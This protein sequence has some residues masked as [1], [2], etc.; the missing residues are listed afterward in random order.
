[1]SLHQLVDQLEAMIRDAKETPILGGA[2]ID[3]ESVYDLVDQ[4]RASIE[5][6][7]LDEDHGT[8]RGAGALVP[9]DELDTFMYDAKS[10][11][12]TGS[13]R[14]D[15][16]RLLAIVGRVR[17]GAAQDRYVT[18]EE[19]ERTAVDPRRART[20]FDRLDTL[21]RKARPVPLTTQVRLDKGAVAKV[22]EEL[23]G[24]GPVALLPA[25]DA[26]DD[27]LHNAHPVPLT[28]EV[29]V[30]RATLSEIYQQMRAGFSQGTP[31]ALT[32]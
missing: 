4:M 21:V 30:E 23:R 12:L 31:P 14:V 1:M 27:L 28:N 7:L 17:Q 2:R 32:N 29:R 3:R 10:V 25:I 24:W 16:D 22:V 6:V 8:Y 18:R 9:L 19:F 20:A 13:V 11:P 5:F 26:L 15:R